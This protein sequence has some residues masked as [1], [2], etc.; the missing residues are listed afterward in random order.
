M[1]LMFV[2]QN[3]KKVN[4][5]VTSLQ[6]VTNQGSSWEPKYGCSSQRRLGYNFKTMDI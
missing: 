5:G 1:Q 3:T 6:Y 2:T 4:F